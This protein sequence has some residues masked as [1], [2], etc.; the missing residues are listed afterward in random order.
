MGISVRSPPRALDAAR[1]AE[2]G[3][4]RRRDRVIHRFGGAVGAD[5]HTAAPQVGWRRHG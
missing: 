4:D 2:Y 1:R 3:S 5:I